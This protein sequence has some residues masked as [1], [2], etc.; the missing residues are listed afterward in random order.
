VSEG[1]RLDEAAVSAVM[2]SFA[3]RKWDA[4]TEAERLAA[5]R[6]LTAARMKKQRKAK[7]KKR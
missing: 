4:M 1:T 2:A 3:H 5:G 7:G 6:K